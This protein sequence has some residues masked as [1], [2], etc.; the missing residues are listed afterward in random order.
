VEKFVKFA[1]RNQTQAQDGEKKPEATATKASVKRFPWIPLDVARYARPEYINAHYMAK[2]LAE[3]FMVAY[4]RNECRGLPT[5]CT[6]LAPILNGSWRS[7]EKHL[8]AIVSIQELEID[9]NN[10]KPMF[11]CNWLDDAWRHAREVSE[12]RRKAANQRHANA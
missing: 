11:R 1:K 8:E 9:D 6:L 2:S 7:I 5:S 4:W 3:A 10:G 12:E